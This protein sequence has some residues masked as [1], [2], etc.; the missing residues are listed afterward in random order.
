MSAAS[1]WSD[2]L[3]A[4]VAREDLTAEQTAWAMDEIMRGEATPVRVAGFLSHPLDGFSA[5]FAAWRERRRQRAGAA[6]LMRLEPHMLK[7]IGV[8]MAEQRGG[9]RAML[10][11]HP[12]VLAT[13]WD[14]HRP[15]AD[16]ER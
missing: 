14:R 3:T 9:V 13:T 15:A 2:L 1:T 7:D 10:K 4:L 16:D 11:W 8:P 5:T 6:L 12:A